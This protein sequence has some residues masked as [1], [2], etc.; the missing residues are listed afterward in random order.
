M[1]LALLSYFR[2]T[3]FLF[4]ILFFTS[5]QMSFANTLTLKENPNPNAAV[6]GQL[7][8]NQKFIL[9]YQPPHS[10]WI[11][12][13][14]PATGLVGWILQTDLSNLNGNTNITPT[15]TKNQ[16]L[17]LNTENEIWG[18]GCQENHLFH[19]M[20]IIIQKQNQLEIQL[21]FILNYL[22]TYPNGSANTN[23]PIVITQPNFPK[24]LPNQVNVMPIITP[25]INSNQPP[26][27]QLMKSEKQNQIESE[28]GA[29]SISTKPKN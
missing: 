16:A 22:T 4:F 28:S 21:R 13:A 15:F 2:L 24:P 25:N 26:V 5:S 29:L 10:T 14:D 17:S 8:S 11:K 27:L 18:N 20:Q 9:I 3:S 1:K 6:V 7:N 19:C 23:F 12:I